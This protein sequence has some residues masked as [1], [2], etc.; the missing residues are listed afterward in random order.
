VDVI[1]VKQSNTS[2]LNVVLS[3]T[4]LCL[5]FTYFL[6]N[7]SVNRVLQSAF[8]DNPFNITVN[9]LI[10]II[11][12]LVSLAGTVWFLSSNQR[13]GGRGIST[14]ELL[15]HLLIPVFTSVTLAYA[16]SQLIRT[17]WWWLVYL[18]GLVLLAIVL[19]SEQAD[20]NNVDQRTPIPMISLT[21]LSIGL[22]LLGLVVMRTIGPRLYVL[23]PLVG[24]AS[25]FV[26]FRFIRLRTNRQPAWEVIA[27][28]VLILAQ[29]AAALYYLF[30]NA[31]QFGII[32]TGLLY[33]LVTFSV[34]LQN[35]KKGRSLF[36]E[37]L[38]MLIIT[39]I[40]T[41]LTFLF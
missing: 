30:I 20:M 22:Y 11:V 1:K 33:C 41:G 39:V 32:L 25:A 8:G 40:L 18:I 17:P 27:A 24:L 7:E 14:M 23:I 6:P 4:G 35:E 10:L 36:T 3:F 38:S 26:A 29:L 28:I 19:I 5:G 12:A 34:G 15:P 9:R 31:L 2:H 37:P 13:P 21:S 16:L